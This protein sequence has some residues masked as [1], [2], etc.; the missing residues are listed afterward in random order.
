MSELADTVLLSRSGMT[1]RIDRLEAAGLVQRHECAAD[2]RGAYAAITQEGLERLER[3]R[4]THL[5][6]IEE[7][8]VSRLTTAI[9]HRSA[10]R[11]RSSF[12][13][14]TAN[15][16]GRLLTASHAR[17]ALRRHQRLRLPGLVARLLP[18]RHCGPRS[19]LRF[20]GTRFQACELNNTFYARPTRGEGRA[21]ARRHAVRVPVLREGQRGATMRALRSDPAGSVA[22]LTE[23]VRPF[24]E[25]L[26]TVLFRVPERH[27]PRRCA[28]GLAARGVAA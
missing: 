20:Y 7:H 16:R 3:A 26:G 25:R 14:T 21:L 15:R 4:P 22:W 8:F 13:P 1:R 19:L 18:A 6:G 9:S 12:R 27:P 5:R 24:G 28:A 2:R 17:P 23:A 10:M 11:S